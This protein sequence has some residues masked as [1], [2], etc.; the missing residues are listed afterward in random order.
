M[1]FYLESSAR[2]RRGVSGTWNVERG[3]GKRGE[4]RGKREDGRGK[5]EEGRGDRAIER[6]SVRVVERLR[7]LFCIEH[8]ALPSSLSP[9]PSPL[10][11]DFFM[12]SVA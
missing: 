1:H 12:N 5:R 6:S 7:D 10:S 11:P 2:L 8:C 9:L 3:L 4:G